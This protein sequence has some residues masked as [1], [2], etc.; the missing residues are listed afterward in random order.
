[1]SRTLFLVCYDISQ[2][3]RLQK[4]HKKVLAYAV[5]G[6]KSVYECWLTPAERRDLHNELTALIE[7]EEDRVH[8][9]QMDPRIEPLFYGRAKRQPMQPFMIV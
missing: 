2:P 4:V 8:F 5:G 1:M 9:F 7:P 6:Q 3:A